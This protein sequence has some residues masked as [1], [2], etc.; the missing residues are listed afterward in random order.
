MVRV[1]LGLYNAS[2]E[3]D[4]LVAMLQRI[5]TGDCGAE[6]NRVAETG[7]YEPAGYEDAILRLLLNDTAGR[8]RVS[9]KVTTVLGIFDEAGLFRQIGAE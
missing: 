2:N 9:G 5:A 3:I 8:P 4:S 6:Y 7:A 1:S